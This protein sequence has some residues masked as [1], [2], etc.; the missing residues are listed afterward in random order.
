MGLAARQRVLRLGGVGMIASVDFQRRGVR[1][2][3]LSRLNGL[4]LIFFNVADGL[5]CCSGILVIFAFVGRFLVCIVRFV[6]FR[7]RLKFV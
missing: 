5:S 4:I 7:T 6:A 3:S 2:F 1:M